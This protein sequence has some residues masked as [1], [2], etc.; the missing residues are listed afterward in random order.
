MVFAKH[1]IS[2]LSFSLITAVV[3]ITGLA[4][5]ASAVSLIN[6]LTVPGNSTELS[7]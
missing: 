7:L 3:N 4:N 1:W 6:G 2:G 5:P